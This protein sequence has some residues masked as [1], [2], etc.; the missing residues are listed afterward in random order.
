[1]D[2]FTRLK[3]R[4]QETDEAVLS[5]CLESAKAIIMSRRFPYG[6]YPKDLEPRYDDL[7]FRIA[8]ELYNKQGAEGEIVHNEHGVNRSYG[9]AWVSDQLLREITPKVGVVT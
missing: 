2:N 8:L 5:D 1:M 4:T 7:Q 3:L 6:D 9:G